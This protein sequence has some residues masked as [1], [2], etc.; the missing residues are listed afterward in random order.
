MTLKTNYYLLIIVLIFTIIMSFFSFIRENLNGKKEF[1][2]FFY[3]KLYTKPLGWE[4]QI[5]NYRL[6]GIKNNDTI[7]VNNTGFELF[8]KDDY[9]YYITGE[10]NSIKKK[11]FSEE[12]Y[13][14]R[15]TN[16]GGSIGLNY[17]NYLLI[18]ENF[19]PL[20]IFKD[21]TKYT[22]KVIF[23]TKNNHYE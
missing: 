23:S 11:E 8:S 10:A 12:Y 15:L 17:D 14:K 3:W 21:S 18:E 6:Y 5:K 7:R 22:I 1:Y 16:F 4:Y 9:Y 20:E 2:P 13:K 19:N